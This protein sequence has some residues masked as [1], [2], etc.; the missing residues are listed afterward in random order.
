MTVQGLLVAA[1]IAL[2]LGAGAARRLPLLGLVVVLALVIAFAL[3]RYV[4][5]LAYPSLLDTILLI[6]VVQAGY[7]VSA[8]LP[9]GGARRARTKT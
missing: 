8:L 4:A 2:V 6:A 5:G 7:L 9:L 3:A 1:L